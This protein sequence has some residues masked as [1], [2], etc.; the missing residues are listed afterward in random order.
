MRTIINLT[1]ILILLY[2][3]MAAPIRRKNAG[4]SVPL[5]TFD[6]NSTTTYKWKLTNDPVMGG[7]SVSTYSLDKD[8]ETVDWSGE[9]KIVPSLQAPGFCNLETTPPFQKFNDA[10]GATHMEMLARSTKDYTGFKLSF[11]ANTLNPQFKCFKA[12]YTMKS[13]GD[14]EW[15]AIPLT[16]F[17]NDWSP[18]TGE[19]KTKCADDA[20]VCP[21][22]RDLAAIEQVGLWMEGA[23]GEFDF[24]VKWIGMG[25]G[26]EPP[27][28][29][30]E[31]T[32]EAPQKDK[33]VTLATFD[34]KDDT[35]FDWK[36]TNDP[37]MGGVSVSNYTIVK[38]TSD[39]EWT[40][41]VKIVPS[42]KAPGFCAL[43]TQPPFAKFNDATG[44]THMEMIAR[45]SLDFTG[46]KLSFAANTLNPQFKC[47]KSDYTMQSSGDWEWIAIPLTNFSN[48]WS[49]STG[50]P[51]TKCSDDARVC[52]T[53]RDL[54]AIEQLGIWMEGAQGK[55]DF[56][57]KWIG[58]GDGKEP[59]NLRKE[60]GLME[61]KIV[62]VV[63]EERTCSQPVQSKLRW[64]LES[65]TWTGDELMAEAICC[66][67]QW[68]GYAEPQ[69]L[70][71]QV[72]MFDSLNES[73]V[74][75]FYDP[76][77]GLPLFK[78][79]MGEVLMISKLTPQNTVGHRLEM[80]NKLKT[81]WSKIMWFIQN[82][83]HVLVITCQ[84]KK[85]IVIVLIL[86]VYLVL[87]K[88]TIKMNI[89]KII[90]FLVYHILTLINSSVRV[91]NT[92]YFKKQLCTE[93]NNVDCNH[94]CVSP[95]YFWVWF[96]RFCQ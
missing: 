27:T 58:M 20:R 68:A 89:W 41:E 9:V 40:G 26:Q 15:I 90:L 62:T 3:A 85:E 22:N 59:K 87:K 71:Q 16:N 46:F 14:W 75:V 69:F 44:A 7:V 83:V 10:T 88:T 54:A 82:V 73:G 80:G 21:T 53:D 49:P 65:L 50:E 95:Y 29:R 72:K 19:P 30:Q 28:L 66:D 92:A 18:A 17:S 33:T 61:K 1:T 8:N 39:L 91:V 57:V 70:F 52:P 79:P 96:F 37:V 74:N 38:E 55:F 43:Q 63:Q 78:A 35:F 11:A 2:T 84:T 13:N 93:E 56:D 24:E 31:L 23:A 34:D 48:D 36:L 81:L 45:S 32:L 42:L 47:F 86:Y 67:K 77:C 64:N 25:D 12:D 4:F 94:F 60:L 76:T 51:N 6:G 5:V